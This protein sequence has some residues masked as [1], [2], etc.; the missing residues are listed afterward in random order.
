MLRVSGGEKLSYLGTDKRTGNRHYR[1]SDPRLCHTCVHY[2]QCSSAKNGRKVIRLPLE[3]LK[4][5][6][7]A[8]YEASKRSTLIEKNASSFPLDT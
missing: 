1:I 4:E 5:R 7:E 3:A 2:G 8:Q 6:L